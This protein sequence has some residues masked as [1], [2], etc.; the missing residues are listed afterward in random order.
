FGVNSPAQ[1]QPVDDVN[2]FPVTEVAGLD[3]DGRVLV[4]SAAKNFDGTD[5][6]FQAV[7][8]PYPAVIGSTPSDGATGVRPTAS[9]RIDFNRPVGGVSPSTVKLLRLDGSASGS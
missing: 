3:L 7:E 6:A 8:I 2:L 1:P 9:L 4:T 5:V